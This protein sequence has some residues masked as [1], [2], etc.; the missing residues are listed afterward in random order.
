[1]VDPDRLE[2]T[3]PR[4]SRRGAR[5]E[6]L[7]SAAMYA[8]IFGS[9][10]AAAAVVVAVVLLQAPPPPPHHP[11]ANGRIVAVKPE[12]ATPPDLRVPEPPTPEA[13]PFEPAL[14]ARGD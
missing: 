9:A 6:G 3:N 11:G 14:A 12:A 13:S 8:T 2:T 4:R 10:F 5:R 7:S 1:M